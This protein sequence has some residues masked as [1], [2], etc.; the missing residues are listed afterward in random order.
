[1]PDIEVERLE[2]LVRKQ[3]CIQVSF[4]VI[5]EIGSLHLPV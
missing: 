4:L 3:V 5:Y 1:M 2:D